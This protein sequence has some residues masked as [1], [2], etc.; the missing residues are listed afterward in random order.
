[1]D[2]YLEEPAIWPDLHDALAAEIRR[3]LNASLPRPFYARLEMRNE[4]GIVD[5]PRARMRIVPDVAVVRPSR[6]VTA[7][8]SPGAGGGVAVA[9]PALS[10]ISPSQDVVLFEETIRH[11]MVE[12]RDASYGHRLVTLIEIL[13][14]SNKHRGPD[15]DAYCLKREE[16]WQAK[17]SLIEIDLLRTGD[18]VFLKP[19]L[20]L[21][22]AAL[23]PI[24]N[25]LVQVN[26]GW[27][28]HRHQLFPF[29]LSDRLPVIPVP[30]REGITEPLLNLQKVFD[31]AY[32][33]G[34]YAL[35]AV[36]YSRPP[37][38][39]ASAAELAWLDEQLRRAG[40]RT[41]PTGA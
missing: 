12:V 26:R 2:P 35:G 32:D 5:E 14:P 13:S 34:P 23:D 10:P 17:V 7:S 15:Q 37:D 25:Y 4:L 36:D 41:N 8:D 20:Q 22:F 1:M 11:P 27:E 19:E 9:E 16:I 40:L 38:P 3:T 18:R 39:P 31:N 30:L 29:G 33:G 24:P 6:A 28:R 21:W